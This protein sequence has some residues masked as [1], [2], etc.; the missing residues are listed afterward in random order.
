MA[1]KGVGR[2][3]SRGRVRGR[4]DGLV[5]SDRNGEGGAG[6]VEQPLTC[7]DED[8]ADSERQGCFAFPRTRC[9]VIFLI[10]ATNL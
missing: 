7:Y 1:W 9:S 6:P 5:H 3:R 8:V 10:P 2:R 4:G